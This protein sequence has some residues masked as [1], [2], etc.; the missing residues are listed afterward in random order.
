MLAGGEIT[1]ND[2][3]DQPIAGPSS[4]NGDLALGAGYW[5][6]ASVPT[7][8]EPAWFTAMPRG[9]AIALA[10]ETV[11]EIDLLGFHVYRAGAVDGPRMRLTEDLLPGQAP[12]TPEGGSYEF[13][14]AAAAPGVT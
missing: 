11:S 3:L 6:G 7:A 8:V 1:L 14:D 13:V 9:G 10:W 2:T 4:G 5:Y 12:G